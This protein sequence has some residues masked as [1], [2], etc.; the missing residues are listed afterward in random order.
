[1]RIALAAVFAASPALAQM[2]GPSEKTWSLEAQERRGSLLFSTRMRFE[3]SSAGWRVTV[4][5][6]GVNPI[7]GTTVA[8]GGVGEARRTGAKIVGNA[9]A[10]GSF[11]ADATHLR[12]VNRD[13]AS[14]AYTRRAGN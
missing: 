9:G 1:M 6:E 12:F 13:C 14:A 4:E 7:Q 10:L 5:C 11:E 3:R 2:P 8:L